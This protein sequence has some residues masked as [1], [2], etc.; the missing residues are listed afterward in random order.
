MTNLSDLDE[1]ILECRNTQA[2]T[3]I[4]EAIKCYHSG[5]YRACIVATWVTVVF[6]ILSK[7]RELDLSGDKKAKQIIDGYV[8]C[9][10]AAGKSD[11]Y[12]KPLEFER[13]ILKTA[14]EFELL[15]SIEFSDLARIQ[16][17]RNRCAHPSMIDA[18]EIYTP[19]AELARAHLRHAVE[20]VLSRPPVQGKAAFD[21]IYSEIESE[22]FPTD[23]AEALKHFEHGPLARASEALIR[24]LVTGITKHI[25]IEEPT[26]TER[27]RQFSALN[28]IAAMYPNS[29][30]KTLA[31]KFGDIVLRIEDKNWWRVLRFIDKAN[32]PWELVPENVQSQALRYVQNTPVKNFIVGAILSAFT[33]SALRDAAMTRLPEFKEECF[34]ILVEVN[35]PV[36]TGADAIERYKKVGSFRSAEQI[37][38]NIILPMAARLSGVE[39]AEVVRIALNESQIWCAGDSPEILVE[40]FQQTRDKLGTSREA[41]REFLTAMLK[42]GK[43][44]DAHYAYPELRKKMI[45]AGIWNDQETQLIINPPAPQEPT[46]AAPNPVLPPIATVQGG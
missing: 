36:I 13:D 8:K 31:A 34:E 12:R 19:P 45:D 23:A 33:I 32:M 18:E 46:P 42:R 21:R 6:D 2:K 10:E 29:F 14:Q 39:V 26:I 27:D 3:Y 11:D 44:P 43:D 22:Y 9:C 24:D 37:G 28:A 16:E 15:N 30:E 38:K 41:W 4:S 40:L 20:H 5:A 25:L 1:L 17:D 7:L 35:P